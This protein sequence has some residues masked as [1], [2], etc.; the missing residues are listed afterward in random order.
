MEFPTSGSDEGRMI[1][2][3]RWWKKRRQ[4]RPGGESSVIRERVINISEGPD[5]TPGH[6]I[7]RIDSTLLVDRNEIRIKNGRVQ[8][9]DILR[10][11]R[12]T[13]VLV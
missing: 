4:V 13:T 1:R 2:K 3:N 7:P 5:A 6:V 10:H 11:K 8:G 12:Q 9:D